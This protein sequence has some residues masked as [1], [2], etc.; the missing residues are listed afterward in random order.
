MSIIWPV[1]FLAIFDLFMCSAFVTTSLP[2][3]ALVLS[4]LQR[5]NSLHTPKVTSL[6]SNS[7]IQAEQHIANQYPKFYYLLQQN[8]TCLDRIRSTS[9]G[10]AIFAPSEE[11]MDALGDSLNL[12]EYG[13]GDADMLPIVQAMASYHLVSVPVTVEKMMQFN[14]ICTPEGELPVQEYDGSIYV[15]GSRVVQ[16]YRFED[17]VVTN[18]QDKDGNIL[19][20]ETSEEEESVCLIYEMEGMVCPEELWG[21]LYQCYQSKSSEAGAV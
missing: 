8:P 6:Y 21:A 19:G 18:Y 7:A 13:C 20:S 5:H 11:S 2:S 17:S 10:F 3:H 4:T 14:V 16:C 1:A 12:L 9:R 15:N